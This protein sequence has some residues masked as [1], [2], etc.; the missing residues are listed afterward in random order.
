MFLLQALFRENRVEVGIE[1]FCFNQAVSS[2]CVLKKCEKVNCFVL[3][4]DVTVK[5]VFFE[6]HLILFKTGFQVFWYFLVSVLIN[7]RSF[8]D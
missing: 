2:L 7:G 3:R 5:Q 1:K 8:Q 4:E 6:A